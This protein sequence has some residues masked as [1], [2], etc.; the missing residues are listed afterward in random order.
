MLSPTARSSP[1]KQIHADWTSNILDPL[2]AK[3]GELVGKLVANVLVNRPRYA[4]TAGL[5]QAF[6]ARGNVHAVPVDIAAVEDDVA[7]VDAGPKLKP[8]LFGHLGVVPSYALLHLDGALHRFDYAWK[9]DQ[10]SVAGGLDDVAVMLPD[11]RIQDLAPERFEAPKR[12]FLIGTHKPAVA[13][14][15]DGEDRCKLPYDT[16]L[17]H[18]L[19][20]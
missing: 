9:L 19:L 12:A 6:Q 11:F 1:L 3:V 2:F 15:I 13:D 4:Y 7:E 17:V 8:P 20:S 5:S 14:N 10:D 18:G 16:L